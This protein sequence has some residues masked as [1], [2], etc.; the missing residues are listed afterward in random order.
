MDVHPL[1]AELTD[2]RKQQGIDRSWV[3]AQ[4][5]VRTSRLREWESGEFQ[6]SLPHLREWTAL[7]GRQPA[8]QPWGGLPIVGAIVPALIAR[9]RQL[10]LSRAEV[11][12]RCDPVM[13]VS[14]LYRL[15]NRVYQPGLYVVG[16]WV[17]ALECDLVSVPVGALAVAA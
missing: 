17:A 9:R 5:E 7:F 14:S 1:V 10:G 6:P 16:L 3:A 12:R 11:G 4:L 13:A 15:E 2:L 8:V